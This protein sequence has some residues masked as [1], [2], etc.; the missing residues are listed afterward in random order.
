MPTI[1]CLHVVGKDRG[2]FL[3]NC[4]VYSVLTFF[5]SLLPSLGVECG[6]EQ[7]VS[8]ALLSVLCDFKSLGLEIQKPLFCSCWN[9]S[10]VRQWTL[11]DPPSGKREG[12]QG[13]RRGG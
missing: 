2:P 10:S 6:Q 11:Q 8:I 3:R 7:M 5:L 1:R 12:C 9:V 4:T 13:I